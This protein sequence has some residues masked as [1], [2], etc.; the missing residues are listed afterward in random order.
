MRARLIVAVTL[1]LGLTVGSPADAAHHRSACQKAVKYTARCAQIEVYG[2]RGRHW[3]TATNENTLVAFKQ[4]A[5]VGASFEADAWVLSDGTAVIFHDKRLGRV[6]DRDS[7][8]RGVTART[9]ITSLT[10]AQFRQ[11]QTK[12]GQPLMTLER[13]LKFAGRQSVNGMIEDKYTLLDPV[14]VSDWV[15]QFHAPVVFYQ[16]PKCRQGVPEHPEFADY[17]MTV[18]AKYIGAC[19]PSPQL[20][21]DAGFAFLI[22]HEDAI[23]PEYVADAHS[24][25][26]EVGNFNSGEADVWARLVAAGADYLLVPH[27]GKAER[28]L[29]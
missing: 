24:H 14:Q 21:A 12:G 6:V 22:T 19:A 10:T 2:H 13:L 3:R 27:P 16:T 15:T 1:L 4:D 28:W 25:G 8:P 11:L 29:K 20:L 5:Q 18:G 9:T 23:T 17:G 26:L 7:M